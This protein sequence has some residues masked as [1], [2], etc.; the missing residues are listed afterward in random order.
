MEIKNISFKNNI[1]PIM[2]ITKKFLQL[3]EGKGNLS[4]IRFIQDSAIGLAPKAIFARTKA[5]LAENSFLELSESCLVYYAPSLLGSK[6]FKNV[7]SKGLNTE[8]QKNI[9]KPAAEFLKKQLSLSDKKLLRIKAAISLGCLAIPICEYSLSYIKNLFT[10][11]IFKTGE[12]NNIANLSKSKTNTDKRNEHV[13]KSAITHI[14]K[15][16]MI[17]GGLLTSSIL[18]ARKGNVSKIIDNISEFI[19]APGSKLFKNNPKK[20]TLINKYFGLDFAN[21]NGKLA[22]SHGQLTSCVL[23][24]GLGYFGA[25]KDRGKQ[26][27]LEVASTFPLVGSYIICGNEFLENTFRKFL[28]KK[29]LCKYVL[30]KDLSVLPFD[31]LEEVTKILATGNNE[32]KNEIYKKLLKQKAFISLVPFLFGIGV[33]GFFV[34]GMSRMFTK[35]RYN[36]DLKKLKSEQD[37]FIKY[38]QQIFLNKSTTGTG[39]K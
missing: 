20:A 17:Y 27:L 24:G 11:R 35:M 13:K 3:Q 7:Y 9:V 2:S 34:V 18:F 8:Q 32:N 6:V 38:N 26:N 19:L 14:K 21:K 22:M 12:F 36:A 29:N 15:A 16:A 23:L 28:Y 33:M 37:N 30:N 10:L 25:A 4:H 31:K 1:N 39:S 5:D